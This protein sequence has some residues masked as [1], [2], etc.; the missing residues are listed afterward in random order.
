M[1]Y[2]FLFVRRVANG[3]YDNT[4][5]HSALSVPAI[6]QQRDGV[7]SE[8]CNGLSAKIILLAAG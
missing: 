7:I 3:S 6:A 8:T 4:L 1:A 2:C 5:Q